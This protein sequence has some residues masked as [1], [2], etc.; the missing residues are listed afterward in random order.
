MFWIL[1]ILFVLCIAGILHS[2]LFYP[3]FLIGF[4]NRNKSQNSLVY[5]SG[6]EM[7]EVAVLCAA[8]NEE[9]VIR[10]KI[11]SVFQTNYPVS[12]LKFYIG[13]DA[14]TDKT[15][16]II[17]ELQQKYSGL[18]LVNFPGRT[19]KSG[20]INKLAEIAEA[21][22]FI[23]TDANVIFLPDT[24]TNIV[25]NFKNEN[26][27]QVAA[28]IIKLSPNNEGIAGQEK[29][30]IGIEN[31]I[32]H[33][34]GIRWKAVMGA[35]G[36]CYAIRRSWYAPVPPKFYMDDFYITMN[37]LERDGEVLFE[38]DAMCNEDVPTEATEEFKRKVRIS[39]GNFQNLNRYRKLLIPFWK[40]KGFAF[41]SHKV[42]RWYTPFFL[43]ASLLLCTALAFYHW[44]FIVLAIGQLLLI[45]SP[46]FDKMLTR[47]K[48]Q[49]GLLRYAAHFYFMNLA[50]LKGF[51]EYSKGVKS[52]IWEP[53]KRNT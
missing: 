43:I 33:C 37:V 39:I 50:L 46:L 35:E 25:K 15:N 44:I 48:I 31:K 34:E 40:G 20:I 45:L 53:T 5:S 12:K 16:Q 14:S 7:P 8:Y 11:E 18:R 3:L 10:E 6:T 47:A 41:L 42:L 9:K 26:V 17:E 28:N 1:L 4:T 23:L 13:S 21:E 22:V 27:Q 36:G 38:P 2:Y 52:N 49:I 19:G 30:Y 29:N 51:I 24:L 32:K